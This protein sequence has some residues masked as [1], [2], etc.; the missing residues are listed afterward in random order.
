MNNYFDKKKKRNRNK[1]KKN[2]FQFKNFFAII[3]YIIF[4]LYK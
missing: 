4:L 1:Y 2:L 3:F